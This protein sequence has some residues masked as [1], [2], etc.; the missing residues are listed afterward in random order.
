MAD[1]ILFDKSIYIEKLKRAGISEDQ[2]RA[3]AEAMEEALREAVA[4]RADVAALRIDLMAYEQKIE[5]AV[6][7][8]T[9]RTGLMAVAIVGILASIEFFEPT[10]PPPAHPSSSSRSSRPRAAPPTP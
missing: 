7:K 3:H 5:R 9:I 1:Q 10:P 4:T 6:R 2:A 8:M